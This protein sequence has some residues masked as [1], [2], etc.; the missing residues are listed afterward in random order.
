MISLAVVPGRC[1]AA[2]L[3]AM[4]TERQRETAGVRGNWDKAV[5]KESGSAPA[6]R[7]GMTELG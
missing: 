3:E 5:F 7:P 1:G 4:D 6:A 2:D